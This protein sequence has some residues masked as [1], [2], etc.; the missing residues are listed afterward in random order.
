MSEN[1]YLTVI[2][3]KPVQDIPKESMDDF[4]RW[5]NKENLKPSQALQNLIEK[6]EL[7]KLDT[8]LVIE[9]IEAAFPG[10]ELGSLRGYIVDANYPF[11][12]PEDL[13]HDE[14]DDQILHHRNNPPQ[15]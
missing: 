2:H 13:S 4:V 5:V 12:D 8:M 9:L 3:N 15:W 6:Y 7:T 10:I 14:F 11:C 1:P